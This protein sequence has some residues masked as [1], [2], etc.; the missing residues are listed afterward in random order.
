MFVADPVTSVRIRAQRWVWGCA[1]LL[2]LSAAMPPGRIRAAEEPAAGTASPDQLLL[3]DYRPRSIFKV[4]QTRVER[5]R[6][7]VMDVHSHAYAKSEAEVDRWVRTMDAVGI[8][9]TVVLTGAT[10]KRFDELTALYGRHSDR[11]ELWCGVDYTGFDAPGFG[12]AAV[13]ELERCY[14]AG[15]RGVGELSDKGGGLR[16]NSGGMHLDDPRMDSVLEKCAELGLP[17]NIH[18]GEDRWMYEPMDR[19]NDGLMNAFRWRIPER[20]DV[21]RHDEVIATLDRAAGRHPHTIFIACHFANSCHD[22]S[23]LGRML[24]AHPNLYAD[25]SARFGETA[26]IP[27]HVSRF[28]EQYQDRLL[29]GTDMGMDPEMYRT[30]FR[31]LET[32]DEHFYAQ[33]LFNYHWPLHGFGL[34]E[35][36]LKKLYGDNARRLLRMG[37]GE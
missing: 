6:F 21:L 12:P 22:L 37:R 27:R 29:Y 2:S 8:E 11:F 9:R 32:E 34:S 33:H 20:P 1:V 24:D 17:V 36:V 15:A 7:P 3:R 28:Y 25:I 13:A 4:P 35:A 30:T 23:V 26:P 18:V 31:I 5:A 16:G 19:H 14:R 10:G